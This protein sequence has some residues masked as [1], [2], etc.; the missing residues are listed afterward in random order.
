MSGIP[1]HMRDHVDAQERAAAHAEKQAFLFFALPLLVVCL[2]SLVVGLLGGNDSY[3]SFM[4][5]YPLLAAFFLFSRRSSL[6]R[7]GNLV[8]LEM[9]GWRKACET[10]RADL[11][12]DMHD[13]CKKAGLAPVALYVQ[14]TK[15]LNAGAVGTKKDEY[16]IMVTSA[17]LEELSRDEVRAVLAHEISHLV[18]E[19]NQRITRIAATMDTLGAIMAVHVMFILLQVMVGVSAG[20]NWFALMVMVVTLY[21]LV[22]ARRKTIYALFAAM[23]SREYLA[24]AGGASLIGHKAM[25]A[26]L[27]ALLKHEGTLPE[28]LGIMKKWRTHPDP[29][30]RLCALL[31][32]SPDHTE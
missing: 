5:A 14:Q 32:G 22:C 11:Y 12:E 3:I 9:Q 25:A 26:G 15:E 18:N 21:G 23:R 10:Y 6:T 7:G 31:T 19:D 4:A 20:M 27:G 30:K 29:Q 17:L 28:S 8:V 24:D 1:A 2:F 13:L 16:A